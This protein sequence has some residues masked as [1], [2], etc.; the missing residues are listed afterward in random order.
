[1]EKEKDINIR[2]KGGKERDFG[3]SRHIKES[4]LKKNRGRVDQQKKG[5]LSSGKTCGKGRVAR[6]GKRNRGDMRSIVL[7][8]RRERSSHHRGLNFG[9][10]DFG[11]LSLRR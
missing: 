8:K 10:K 7:R 6:K 3:S 11:K 4:G 1:M 2:R 5:S 9:K